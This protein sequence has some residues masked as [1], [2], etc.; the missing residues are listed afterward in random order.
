TA[1]PEI[2]RD[3]QISAAV[4]PWITTA[5]LVASTVMLPIYGKL[6]DVFGRKPILLVG[7]ILFLLG[8]LLCGIAPSTAMLIGARAV[9]GLGAASLFTTTLA[10]IA[11]L[12][13]PDERGKYMGLIGAVMGI[14]SVV[15]PLA[16]GVITDLLGWHWV[17]FINLPVGL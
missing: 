10:V 13:P 12:F 8:S 3:L 4:Y 2:Q 5:Y 11:D 7:V 9:Q 16:G 1:G 14:S 15:G 6:S 17:F